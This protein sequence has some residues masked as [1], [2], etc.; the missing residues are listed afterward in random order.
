[1]VLTL[2]LGLFLGRG[3]GARDLIVT[4]REGG[5]CFIIAIPTLDRYRKVRRSKPKSSSLLDG[6]MYNSSIQEDQRFLY[7]GLALERGTRY[8]SDVGGAY[9]RQ[10]LLNCN[11]TFE[12]GYFA[13]LLCSRNARVLITCVPQD[14]V[15]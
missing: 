9:K 7:P 13:Y 5:R 10:W 3:H 14:N 1:M 15:I 12:V 2:S 6:I 4:R 8:R 11:S